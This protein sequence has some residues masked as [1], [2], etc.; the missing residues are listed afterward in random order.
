MKKILLTSFLLVFLT[1][2]AVFAYETVIIKYP[3]GELWQKGYYKKIGAEAILQY[4]PAGQTSKNWNRSIIVHSYYDSALPVNIF[5]ANDLARMMKTNPTGKY[6]YLKLS[7]VDSIAGRCTDDYKN[8]KGQCEFYR[9][10]R[11]HEGIVSLHYINR[12]KDD[13][14]KNYKQRF[15]IIKKAKFLNTYYRNDRILNKSEY[16]ELW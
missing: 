13:F 15:E 9:V 14:M 12:D 3:D 7:P 10:S 16:F 11:A 2:I 5:I 4:V 6:K 8:V 1:T